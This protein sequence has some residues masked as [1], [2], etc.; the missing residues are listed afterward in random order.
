MH[1]ALSTLVLLLLTSLL[2]CSPAAADKHNTFLLGMSAAFTG[3]SKGL[4][5][6]LY[7]GSTAYFNHINA[8]GGIN[9]HKIVI[10]FLDDGYNPE[11]AIRNT[12][13]L[14]EKD[15]SHRPFQLRGHPRLLPE[16]FRSLSIST[17]K[18]RNTF[19]FLSPGRSRKENFLTKNMYLT[20][21][22]HT[23]RKHGDW[24][25]IFI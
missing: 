9:G 23:D 8:Q 14:V 16:Y 12:I 24:F 10:K 1:K 3:P 15:K 22:L 19:F 11:P 2:L 21:E 4:G 5:I 13:K 7:R 18:S 20:C 6:E 25:T 17:P